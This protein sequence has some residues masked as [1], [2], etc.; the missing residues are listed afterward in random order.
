MKSLHSLV[1]LPLN[2]GDVKPAG[3]LKRQLE[4]QRDGL[5]GHLDLFWP[6]VKDSGWLGGNE[7][8]WERF[9]YWLD[10][11]I[12]LAFLLDDEVFI[13]RLETYLGYILDNRDENGWFG[14]VKWGIWPEKD[15]WPNFVFIKALIQYYQARPSDAILDAIRAY[16]IHLNDRLDMQQLEVWAKSRWMDGVW[17]IQWFIDELV[18]KGKFTDSDDY[19]FDLMEKLHVQGYDWKDHF[20]HF[21]YKYMDKAGF[22][23]VLY[24]D[25]PFDLESMGDDGD[26]DD[27]MGRLRKSDQRSHVVNN[28][29]GIKAAT[30]WSRVSKSDKD[31]NGIIDA[32]HALDEYHG[33]ATGVFSGDEH[34]AG[35]NPSQ[36][37]ELCS[38]VEYMFSLET[39]IPILARVELIDRLERICFN[40]LPATLT[41]DMW[42]HQYDQQAN[43]VQA[44]KVNVPIYTT[45]GSEAN[46]FG[47]EPN[48]GCCTADFNQG[49]PKF[50]TNGLWAIDAESS[51]LVA[52]GF[53]PCRVSTKLTLNG[54]ELELGIVEDTRYPFDDE[55]QFSLQLPRPETFTL[56]FRIPTWCNCATIQ[57]NTSTIITCETGAFQ[58]I[59]RQWEDGDSIILRLP[60]PITYETRYNGAASVHRGPLLF[61]LKIQESWEKMEPHGAIKKLIEDNSINLPTQVADWEIFPDSTWNYALLEDSLEQIEIQYLELGKYIFSPEGAPVSLKMKG[62]ILDEWGL[63]FEVASPPPRNPE[64]GNNNIEEITLIPYGC[65]N[66]R[67]TEFPLVRKK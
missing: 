28:A 55:I 25:E 16:F 27:F 41:P 39:A 35:K 59:T 61:S 53:A 6:D 46:I 44:K 1:L 54:K 22:L 47:L 66:I 2:L 5:S 7:E 21:F 42:A 32:I 11:A 60:S 31:R 56:K 65:T 45:N 64:R 33:Q 3:W 50:V 12:P 52:M 57:V 4:V 38:V 18:S 9:P 67:I 48:Y 63:E 24:N 49:W 37:T 34:L 10:G 26:D 43:Q 23:G 17:G 36:G 30:I 14:P 51:G 8:G 13:K 62:L 19:L 15:P 58:S 20:D 40:A 29:M